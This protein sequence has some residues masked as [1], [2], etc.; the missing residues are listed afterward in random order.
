MFAI[1]A[2]LLA[3]KTIHQLTLCYSP[4]FPTLL[5]RAHNSTASLLAPQEAATGTAAKSSLTGSPS[6][7]T[8][9]HGK[10][11][12]NLCNGLFIRLATQHA[13]RVLTTFR[14]EYVLKRDGEDVQVN[15]ACESTSGTWKSPYDGATW[16][17]AGDLDI[18][19]MV[20]L[21]NAWI[22]SI[23][24]PPS[25]DVHL[26]SPSPAVW[27]FCLDYPSTSSFR[28]RHLPPAAVGRHQRS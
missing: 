5:M 7:E 19:H 18:D 24:A 13:V 4:V 6:A 21:K 3:M 28:Q 20:P 10:L 26:C 1:D 11:P 16:T 8:V 9:T 2:I 25:Q 23:T 22:V 14:S 27:C 17:D 12:P 15:N